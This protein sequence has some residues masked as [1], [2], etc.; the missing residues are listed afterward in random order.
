[1]ASKL[2]E[3]SGITLTICVAEIFSM[4]GVFTFP[5]LLPLF[6]DIWK[7]S[8]IDAGWINGIYFGQAWQAKA[9]SLLRPL[10]LFALPA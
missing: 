3:S 8:S 1:M 2:S 5:A 9:C 4:V 6:A 10:A 7:L